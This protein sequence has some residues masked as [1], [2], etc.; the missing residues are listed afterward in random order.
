MQE[1]HQTLMGRKLIEHDIPEIH[2]QLKRIADSL[3]ILVKREYEKKAKVLTVLHGLKIKKLQPGEYIISYMGDQWR[4][5]RES[6]SYMYWWYG[7]KLEDVGA[8][9]FR[10]DSKN[11]VLEKIKVS[12]NLPTN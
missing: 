3:D 7:E 1:L 11:D 5:Y 12:Y 6:I 9:A 4:V 8:K 2:E 10:A